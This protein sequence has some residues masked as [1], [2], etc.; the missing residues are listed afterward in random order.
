MTTTKPTPPALSFWEQDSFFRDIDVLII[1]SGIV[2][3]NAAITLAE[4][5]PKWKIAILEKGVL[6]S[7]A[8]TRNAGFACFGSMTELLDD[9]TENGEAA[10]LALVEKRWKGLQRL[11]ER[12]GDEGLD[13]KGFGSYELF[14]PKE[15]S[16][17][18]HC[19]E[20]R[21]YLN[22]ELQQIIG[23]KETFNL[24]TES[25]ETFGF[26]KVKELLFNSA[27]GQIDTGRMMKALLQLARD[28]GVNIYNGCT[29]EKIEEEGRQVR[30]F[31]ENG[32]N[33]IA[34]KILLCNNG[35][36][37]RLLPDLDVQ[38]ARNQVLI[39]NEIPNLPIKG[40]FHYDSG[41]FYFRNI[42][43]RVLL[44]GGR[45]LAK[46]EE[47][48]MEFQTTDKI[49]KALTDLLQEVILPKQEI[50]IEQWWSGILGVGN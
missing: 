17:Y 3:L 46:A 26:S 34:R 5:E 36:A 33:L 2:G 45:H 13:Y 41:Y 43:N 37:K 11:R 27:E 30:V 38:P 9:I 23:Q 47:T 16:S 25:L 35:F 44:G 28:K 10:M 42:G 29:V 19:L 7:G 49:K 20:N 50:R 21:E 31:C 32:W 15:E 22:K 4:K 8:S 40:C 24:K 12:V 1:G 6:P 48:T 14:M 18:Q 39:T